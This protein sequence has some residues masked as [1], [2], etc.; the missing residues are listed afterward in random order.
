MGLLFIGVCYGQR[1]GLN[2]AGIPQE[3]IDYNRNS[4]VGADSIERSKL[5][6]FRRSLDLSDVK[7]PFYDS[8]DQHVQRIEPYYNS[9][10]IN[11]NLGSENSAAYLTNWG[12]T[13][14]PG[15]DLG[16]NQYDHL[17]HYLGRYDISDV[18]RS[19]WS[20]HYQKGYGIS[21]GNVAID[22]NRRFNRNL[23][24]NFNYDNY[25]DNSWLGNQANELG[26]L[27]MKFYQDL[28]ERKRKSYLIYSRSK[29]SEEHSRTLSSGESAT[30]DRVSLLAGLG[31]R[32]F[33]SSDSLGRTT[34]LKNEL[35]Y[36]IEKY[37]FSDASVTT[38]EAEN[39]GISSDISSIDFGQEVASFSLNS[40]LE[41]RHFDKSYGVW[42]NLSQKKLSHTIDTVRTFQL[43]IGVDY[44]KTLSTQSKIDLSGQF[45]FGQF[46]SDIVFNGNYFRSLLG[47]AHSLEL[48]VESGMK[49]PQWIHQIAS[50]E[51][52]T[53][54]WNNDFDEV[55]YLKI[56]GKYSLIAS[57]TWIQLKSSIYNSPVLYDE[58]GSP[59]Q[60][61]NDIITA[62]MGVHKSLNFWF[63]TTE[64]SLLL[65]YINDD[66]ILR[67]NLQLNGNV[68]I[69][70]K[71]FKSG[72][73]SRIGVDYYFMPSF[74]TPSFNP[75]FGSFYNDRSGA[76]SG[77]ILVLNP[78]ASFRVDDNFQFY[79]K[80][81]N[82]LSRLVGSDFYQTNAYNIYDYRL[83]FGIKWRL[84][85]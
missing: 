58:S 7:T 37:T 79:F 3:A 30:S 60:S 12:Y 40:Y 28:G 68:A 19:L 10:F 73:R 8:L 47:K 56:E 78:Y 63:L 42:V 83:S 55:K 11:G 69:D 75:L 48:E 26:N 9:D 27:D 1:S 53:V 25:S 81:T 50:L 80:S 32:I 34:S 38:T 71:L 59:F 85:D 62:S 6:V 84:L 64:H 13:N 20:I 22:F 49:S 39:F 17:F 74:T 82:G 41:K 57:K 45:V 2:T 77:Y 29:M 14:S 43:D 67:P 51:T 36:G 44:H 5:E 76:K 66:V 4:N 15:I 65:Q 52:S 72:L 23:L 24:F 61:D 31:N 70:F 18:N 16:Y 46:A 35:L 21:N 33:L 54:L